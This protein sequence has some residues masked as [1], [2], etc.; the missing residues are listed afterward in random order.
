[1]LYRAQD[2]AGISRLGYADSAD[3]IAVKVSGSAR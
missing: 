1:M 2:R 3:G